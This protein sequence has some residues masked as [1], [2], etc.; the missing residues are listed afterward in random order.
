MSAGNHLKSV[1][2]CGRYPALRLPA[3]PAAATWEALSLA[4]IQA[5]AMSPVLTPEAEALAKR[6]R[7]ATRAEERR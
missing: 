4:A 7:H 1:V 3:F 5:A 2:L 6:I